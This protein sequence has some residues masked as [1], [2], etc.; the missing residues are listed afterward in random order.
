MK[1]SV[2]PTIPKKIISP[3][4]SLTRIACDLLFRP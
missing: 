1:L 4:G 2:K 3:R